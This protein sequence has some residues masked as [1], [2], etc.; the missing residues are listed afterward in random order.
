MGFKKGERVTVGAILSSARGAMEPAKNDLEA[1]KA[2]NNGDMAAVAQ[3]MQPHTQVISG[4]MTMINVASEVVNV[5]TERKRQVK[6]ALYQ[7]VN[8]GIAA[9]WQ[10]LEIIQS[11]EDDC[12]ACVGADPDDVANCKKACAAARVKV[13]ALKTKDVPDLL[14]M[15]FESSHV[16]LDS[17]GTFVVPDP[18]PQIDG[19]LESGM[20][21]VEEAKKMVHEVLKVRRAFFDALGELKETNAQS[22]Q[23]LDGIRGEIQAFLQVGMADIVE[24][25]TAADRLFVRLDTLEEACNDADAYRATSAKFVEKVEAAQQAV[26]AGKEELAKEKAEM[27]FSDDS[28]AVVEDVRILQVDILPKINKLRTSAWTMPIEQLEEETREVLEIGRSKLQAAQDR[29]K[30]MQEQ[31]KRKFK[32]RASMFQ[33]K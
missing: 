24:Q 20:K 7:R 13:E 15:S 12:D 4:M 25:I 31:N 28:H 9:L 27:F 29:I 1:S 18:C 33:G 17:E 5:L 6:G 2:K 19:M 26:T 16:K 32:E 11:C 30:A 21:A 23:V 8:R 10:Q 3:D 22:Q 14:H